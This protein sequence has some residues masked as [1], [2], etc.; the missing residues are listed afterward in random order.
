MCVC[1]RVCIERCVCAC[2]RETSLPLVEL[3]YPTELTDCCVKMVF[4]Y[5][6]VRGERQREGRG[7]ERWRERERGREGILN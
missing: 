2:N 6:T 5:S 3:C 1:K 7:E 4:I